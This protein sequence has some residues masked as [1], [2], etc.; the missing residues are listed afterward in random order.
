MIIF[1]IVL[2]ILLFGEIFIFHRFNSS[3]S[4]NNTRASS[5]ALATNYETTTTPVPYETPHIISSES[6][7]YEIRQLKRRMIA[8]GW[9]KQNSEITG[10][11]DVDLQNAIRDMKEYYYNHW[12]NTAMG[13]A[14][15]AMPDMNIDIIDEKTWSLIF[16]N[17]IPASTIVPSSTPT[18]TRYISKT[19]NLNTSNTNVPTQNKEKFTNLYGTPTTRCAHKGYTNYIASSGDTN[20]CT[21]HS[22][23]CLECG[24]YIDEDATWCMSCII[25]AAD[26]IRSGK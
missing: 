13:D 23:R 10:D 26:T 19:A 11:F 16:D 12:N 7:E 25:K 20:C 6:D 4:T 21:I 2:P 5:L 1:I 17:W 3:S 24:K 15:V 8:L 18:P 14:V 9:M 22:R